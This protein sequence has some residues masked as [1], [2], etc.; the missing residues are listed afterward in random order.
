MIVVGTAVVNPSTEQ[1]EL[2]APMGFGT[3]RGVRLSNFTGD[4]I[5][6]TN[7]SGV[8]QSQE[9][10]APQTQMVYPTANVG[11]VPTAVGVSYPP[12]QIAQN[13]LVEWSTD[14][15]AD[16][17]GTY[18]AALP[19]NISSF[20]G[21]ARVFHAA[22]AAGAALVDNEI[23]LGILPSDYA[24]LALSVTFTNPE[25]SWC[26]ILLQEFNAATNHVGAQAGF[27][28]MKE[29]LAGFSLALPIRLT[30]IA[31]LFLT[32][33]KGSA[34]AVDSVNAS[35]YTVPELP[36][37]VPL[38]YMDVPYPLRFQFT[39][40]PPAVSSPPTPE[41]LSL[42]I[43]DN[44]PGALSPQCIPSNNEWYVS[45]QKLTSATGTNTPGWLANDESNFTVPGGPIITEGDLTKLATVS[46]DWFVGHASPVE[47]QPDDNPISWYYPSTTD[48]GDITITAMF[49]QLGQKH[50][51]FF[52]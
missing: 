51:S 25:D 37:D 38:A 8:D 36:D 40:T 11:A 15:D 3:A 4:S 24:I 1:V 35:M 6:L 19:A 45:L 16:F 28:I 5:T 7:I 50:S 18:P 17:L 27:L 47:Y 23:D 2:R 22:G 31:D 34:L 26:Q 49:Y 13:I 41:K 33:S 32:I 52:G 48:V 46:G 14:P 30:H 20:Q 10:L 12:D 44:F 29:D 42:H 21:T 39:G 9:Y 43:Q